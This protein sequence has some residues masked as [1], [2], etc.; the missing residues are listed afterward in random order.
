MSLT[1]KEIEFHLLNRHEV[2]VK[3][4]TV[5]IDIYK[6]SKLRH[7]RAHTATL[8]LSLNDVQE[9]IKRD[10]LLD[11][12]IGLEHAKNINVDGWI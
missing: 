7:N 8:T 2:S 6:G 12:V 10:D 4:N 1:K 9:A 3:A 5:Q 11:L